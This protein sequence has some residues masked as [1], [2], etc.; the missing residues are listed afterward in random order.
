MLD[1]LVEQYGLNKDFVNNYWDWGLSLVGGFFL[2]KFS[3]DVF[4][5]FGVCVGSLS[6]LASV[7]LPIYYK[8]DGPLDYEDENGNE[9]M[10]YIMH[11]RIIRNVLAGSV[12]ILLSALPSVYSLG[13]VLSGYVS[14]SCD[15]MKKELIKK[16][17]N[18]IIL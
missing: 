7:A 4:G 2:S 6:Y 11:L 18:N 12:P 17:N 14:Y 1:E 5:S 16:E 13:A 8:V 9:K 3:V 10:N 15:K